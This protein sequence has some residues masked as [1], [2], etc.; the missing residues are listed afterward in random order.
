MRTP[1][2]GTT[3]AFAAFPR[4]GARRAIGQAAM[5][6]AIRA[7]LGRREPTIGEIS[8]SRIAKRPSALRLADVLEPHPSHFAD[9]G[10]DKGPCRLPLLRELARERPGRSLPRLEQAWDG[11]RPPMA[12]RYGARRRRAARTAS[13]VAVEPDPDPTRLADHGVPGRR[14]ERQSDEARASSLERQPFENLR[15]FLPSTAFRAPP[16]SPGAARAGARW[17]DPTASIPFA[18]DPADAAPSR[19]DRP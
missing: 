18:G 6:G 19:A 17:H 14:A 16:C 1:G 3:A 8:A 2:S 10:L 11:E 7:A 9:L 15:S 5:A 12:A 13:P 4:P